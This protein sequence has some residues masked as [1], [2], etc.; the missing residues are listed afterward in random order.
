MEKKI[1]KKNNKRGRKEDK[2]KTRLLRLGFFAV[3]CSAP[4][5]DTPFFPKYHDPLTRSILPRHLQFGA[6]PEL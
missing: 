5:A 4:D 1:E 6:G 2:K 3:P